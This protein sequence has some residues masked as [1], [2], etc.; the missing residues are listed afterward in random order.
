MAGAYDLTGTPP[1]GVPGELFC[2]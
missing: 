1:F 2:C